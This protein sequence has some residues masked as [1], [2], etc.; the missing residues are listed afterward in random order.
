MNGASLALVALVPLAAGP[1]PQEERTMTVGL[2][3]GGEITIPL[4]D[5]DVPKR[6]CAPK[7]C[8]AATCREKANEKTAGAKGG[9]PI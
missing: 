8:H 9:A 7:A 3:G 4:G 6:D 2:C 1:L 5:G